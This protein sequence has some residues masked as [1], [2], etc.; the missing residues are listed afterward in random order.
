MIEGEELLFSLLFLNILP[1]ALIAILM[2]KQFYRC[3]TTADGDRNHKELV[4]I[5]TDGTIGDWFGKLYADCVQ[6]LVRYNYTNKNF[7]TE[8]AVYDYDCSVYHVVRDGTHLTTR[9]LYLKYVRDQLH[10]DGQWFGQFPNKAWEYANEYEVIENVLDQF[11][12]HHRPHYHDGLGDIIT[13]LMFPDR[14]ENG[15]KDVNASIIPT[16]KV[17]IKTIDD[18]IIAFEA[19]ND[20]HFDKTY[21]NVPLQYIN[22]TTNIIKRLSDLRL[23]VQNSKI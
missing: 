12:H 23:Y 14:I 22:A 11:K 21:Y 1:I 17:A 13:T 20:V 10:P 4:S 2:I 7:I 3:Y 9:G 8:I 15:L 18:C 6:F 19:L 5:E 16:K